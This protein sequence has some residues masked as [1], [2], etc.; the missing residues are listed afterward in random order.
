MCPIEND[1]STTVID[2]RADRAIATRPVAGVLV[3]DT[4]YDNFVR[5][6]G[7]RFVPRCKRTSAVDLLLNS[8]FTE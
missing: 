6:F 7:E 3:P 4:T 8:P 5:D 1:T 2:S